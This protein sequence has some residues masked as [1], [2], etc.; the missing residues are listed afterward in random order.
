MA[1]TRSEATGETPRLQRELEERDRKH[2]A[3]AQRLLNR[4]RAFFIRARRTPF[5]PEA[6]EVE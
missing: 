5:P 4:A 1:Y 6:L 2:D 3:D